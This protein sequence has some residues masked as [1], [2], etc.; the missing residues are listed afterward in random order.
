MSESGTVTMPDGRVVGYATHGAAGGRPVV[1]CHGGPG[2][3]L[4]PAVAGPEAEAAGITFVGIDRPGYGVSTPWPGRSIGGWVPD[5]LAV[6]DAL[7][8]DTFAAVGVS[9][10]GAYALALAA[11]APERVTAV[12][13][14]CALTDM[15]WAEGRAMMPAAAV[16]DLWDAPDRDVALAAAAAAFGEDGSRF[17]AGPAGDGDDPPPVLPPADLAVLTDPAWLGRMAP[18]LAE[19]FASGVQGYCDDRIADGA[20]WVSFDAGAVRAPATVLHGEADPVIPPAHARHT[21][22]IVPGA[23]LRLVPDLG[24]LSIMGEIVPA[25]A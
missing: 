17:L 22:A 2:S 18:G 7:G 8:L 3:R 11:L 1:W 20:G 14:C 5:G 12:V 9:T 10:G 23:T 16:R 13:A 4:E 6:A 25:L 24:H 19:M 21:A 15:T